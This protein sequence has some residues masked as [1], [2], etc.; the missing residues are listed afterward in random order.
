MIRKKDKLFSFIILILSVILVSLSSCSLKQPKEKPSGFE[1]TEQN[2]NKILRSIYN[3]K[4]NLFS[5]I[6]VQKGDTIALDYLYPNE[7]DSLINDLNNYD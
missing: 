1:T 3:V 4:R 7:L 6:Y 5:V 2:N